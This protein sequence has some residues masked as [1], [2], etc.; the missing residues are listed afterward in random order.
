M[1]ISTAAWAKITAFIIIGALFGGVMVMYSNSQF[2]APTAESPREEFRSMFGSDEPSTNRHMEKDF[3]VK[4]GGALHLETDAGDVD[5]E[6]WDKEEVLVKVDIEG[7]DR[8]SER[9]DV[10]FSQDG[11]R[12]NI[13][14]KADDNNFFKWNLGDLD[15][16]YH[17]L[18]PRNFTIK[19]STSGG[20]MTT[21][22]IA[23]DVRLETSGGNVSVSSID[24]VVTINSSG[25]NLDARKIKGS[26]KGETSGGN[27]KATTVQGDVDVETSGG[28]IDLASIEGAVHGET[29]GGGVTLTLTGENKG[30]DLHSSGG[31]INIF[32]S[33]SIAANLEASTSGGKV[34]CELPITVKGEMS[35]DELRGRINGGGNVIRAETSGGDIRIKTI[36]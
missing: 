28:E 33:D 29:S 17:I 22:N 25:G 9:F 18:V 31:D 5:I 13:I 6:S 4:S 11:D 12:V 36:K 2:D 10:K 34:R 16:S 3:S 1:K 21:T 8:R 15:V 35:D 26:L 19:A 24:G 14:G 27:V 23:G 32:V 20:N 30:V 7:S